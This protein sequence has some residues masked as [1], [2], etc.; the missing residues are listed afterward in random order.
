MIYKEKCDS[1]E[2]DQV[3]TARKKE[4]QSKTRK[5]NRED[6]DKAD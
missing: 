3:V 5:Q 4:L 2:W 6:R 1:D